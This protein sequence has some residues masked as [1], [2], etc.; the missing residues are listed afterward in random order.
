VK[1]AEGSVVSLYFDSRHPIDEGD[2]LRTA[3]GRRY[4]I[5]SHRVQ[6]RGK[7]AG[8]H[9]L[10]CLVMRPGDTSE[11]RTFPIY[12]YGRNRRRGR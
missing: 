11:G 9:H 10:T 4:L 12:W 8:R 3:T 1:A 7:R 6:E 5:L 2:V